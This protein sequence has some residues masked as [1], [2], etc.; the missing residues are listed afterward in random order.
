MSSPIETFDTSTCHPHSERT[1]PMAPMLETSIKTTNSKAVSCQHSSSRRLPGAL[2][3]V[4][5]LWRVI[6]VH[7]YPPAGL[8]GGIYSLFSQPFPI[9]VFYP[10]NKMNKK[11][12]IRPRCPI[13]AY[14]SGERSWQRSGEQSS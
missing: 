12:P 4:C 8:Y 6:S 9:H 14:Q 2:R 5:Q 3:R 13:S 1:I 11:T 10:A 7:I